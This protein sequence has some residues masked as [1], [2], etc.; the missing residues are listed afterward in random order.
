MRPDGLGGPEPLGRPGSASGSVPHAP[1]IKSADVT[2]V[3]M[4][5]AI[6]A[7][8]ALTSDLKWLHG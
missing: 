8:G 3:R 5:G 2:S 1:C 7:T 4:G 6:G